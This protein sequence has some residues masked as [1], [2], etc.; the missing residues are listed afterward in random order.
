MLHVGFLPERGEPP[1]RTAFSLG[2]ARELMAR[3][4][5]V[6]A[7]SGSGE[8]LGL[9]DDVLRE[10]GVAMLTRRQVWEQNTVIFTYR[11]PVDG[12]LDLLRPD[13]HIFGYMHAEGSP[14]LCDALIRSGA[15]AFAMEF[16]TDA[17]GYSLLTTV[18]S[19]VSG[20]LAVIHAA[21]CLQ[22]PISNAGRLLARVDGADAVRV[23]VLGNTRSGR[24]A[25]QLALDM[26]AE[27]TLLGRD[28]DRLASAANE[29]GARLATQLLSYD[30][31]QDELDRT[32]VVIG[33]ILI[34]DWDTPP[35]IDRTSLSRLRPGSV[36]VDVTCGYG[37]GYLPTFSR[38]TTAADPFD[39]IDGIVHI[40]ID[41]LPALVPIS[42][43][44]ASSAKLAEVFPA[45][46]DWVANPGAR[47]VAGDGIDFARAMISS[48]GR[49]VHEY[50]RSSYERLGAG[51]G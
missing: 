19:V 39:V 26:G 10:A 45:F 8:A 33:A 49:L 42:T 40:K 27:V 1:R 24:S 4:M 38:F 5:A 37:P 22:K 3:G 20:R 46:A 14:S 18:D 48:G 34:S 31:V 23:M 43:S 36:I 25:A 21:Y 16:V 13:H 11:P 28:R 41:T 30:A 29:C 7:E 15:S 12:D 2:A 9:G 51:A 17:N 32:D 44:Q 50:V 35:L 6:S 47:G